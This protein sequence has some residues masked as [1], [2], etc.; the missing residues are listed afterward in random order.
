MSKVQ[1]PLDLK[2]VHLHF[3]GIKGTGMAALVEIAHRRGAVITGSDVSER[4]Y[5][6]D[7]L[8]KY[9]IKAL[10]F[11]EKN[12]DDSIQ[13]VIYSSAYSVLKNPDLKEAERRNIPMMLYSQA[14][15]SLSESAYSCAVCG[16]H[17]KTTTTGLTGT[18]LSKLPLPAQIL[19]GS[20]ITSFGGTCTLTNEA[21]NQNVDSNFGSACRKCDSADTDCCSSDT[22]CCS[23]DIDC[24]SSDTDCGSSAIKKIFVA[25]TCEYQRHFMAYFPQKIILTSVESDHQDFYPTY[26]DIR[27]AFVD[28]ICKLP[29]G[30]QL[31]YCADDKGALQTAGLALKK[32]PD[33]QFVPYGENLKGAV[34]T[35]YGYKLTFGAVKNACQTFTVFKDKKKLGEFSLYVP[36]RH[37]VRNSCAALALCCELLKEF[38]FNESDYVGQL[39]EGLSMF[40]GGKRRSE[41]VGITKN[42]EG[43]SVV[44]IDDYGHHPTAIRTTLAGYRD[45]YKGRKMIVDFMSHT[46]SRT[47]SLFD[48][49][50]FSFDDADQIILHKIYSSARENASDFTVTGKKLY[51]R[52]KEKYDN[53]HYFEEIMDAKPFLLEELNK[54]AGSEYPEG[55]L[56]VTV[57]AGDNWKIGK[58]LFEELS[59]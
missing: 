21:Y 7:I 25:E 9:G 46:Y 17:G 13:F 58:E 23:S 52:A 33:I 45:F 54:K 57:G 37:L 59:K 36:G 27:D 39:K 11:S 20:Q 4:F 22:D 8:E 29:K 50:A 3:V 56:F 48:E 42:R 32:R 19:A 40:R 5:T 10:P 53:I 34:C 24:C 2:G 47:A 18:L 55:Y 51:E 6:D 35:E 43:D 12:I 16:V 1:L 14:L 26:E 15:G 49:F 44:F 28:F 30:G 38:G 41:V 31:I